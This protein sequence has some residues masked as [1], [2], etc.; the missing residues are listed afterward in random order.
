MNG[1][2]LFQWGDYSEKVKV[3]L[4]ISK[5]NLFQNHWINFNWA[6]S[7]GKGNSSLF[8]MIGHAIFQEIVKIE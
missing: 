4:T 8:E 5:I 7:L 6:L 3:L 2:T 1:H